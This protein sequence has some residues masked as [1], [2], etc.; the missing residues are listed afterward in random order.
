MIQPAPDRLCQGINVA[1]DRPQTP[2]S[3]GIRGENA[4][5]PVP[6]GS[7]KTRGR[8]GGLPTPDDVA[9]ITPLSAIT[10]ISPRDSPSWPQKISTLCSPIS[11]AR[12]EIR[13]GEPL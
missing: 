8:R 3:L 6:G 11:G 1:A 12:L 7:M 4:R 9:Q 10:D 13:Q 2:A 5:K